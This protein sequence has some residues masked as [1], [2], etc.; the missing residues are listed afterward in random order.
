MYRLVSDV[1]YKESIIFLPWFVLIGSS[2]PTCALTSLRAAS[3]HSQHLTAA[4]SDPA[5]KYWIGAQHKLCSS[6]RLTPTRWHHQHQH[7]NT[8]HT[9][10]FM[11]T[12]T[13]DH[14]WPL[15]IHIN[16]QWPLSVQTQK[17]NDHSQYPLR[18]LMI[19]L[20]TDTEGQW[21]LSAQTQKVNDHSQYI[22]RRSMTTLNTDIEGQRPLSV[23]TQ[24]V[25]DHSQYRHRRSMTTLST[26]T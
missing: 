3:S 21:P 10:Q 22:L 1:T 17:V 4:S 15:S 5:T 25:N 2:R 19:T 23:Q 11:T 16:C 9:Q 26:D 18:R 14:P 24:K 12:V 7:S 20:S 6:W 8:P 13:T